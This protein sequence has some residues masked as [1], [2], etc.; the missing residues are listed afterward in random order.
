MDN[1][2]IQA[3]EVI[4]Y[5]INMLLHKPIIK[6]GKFKCIFSIWCNTNLLHYNNALLTIYFF[7]FFRWSQESKSPCR[8]QKQIYCQAWQSSSQWQLFP[9]YFTQRTRKVLCLSAPK[10]RKLT[11]QYHDLYAISLNDN[12]DFI[13]QNIIRWNNGDRL[14]KDIKSNCF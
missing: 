13:W 5:K 2:F 11:F 12:C 14:F 8:R 1:T 10:V 9:Q 3:E 4:I 7:F 6:F